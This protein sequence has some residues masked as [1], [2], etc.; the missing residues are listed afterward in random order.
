MYKVDRLEVQEPK[1]TVENR[2]YGSNGGHRVRSIRLNLRERL[3]HPHIFL[4]IGKTKGNT[5][6]LAAKKQ[7]DVNMKNCTF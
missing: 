4:N 2:V 1:G 7:H 3:G 5:L 6:I